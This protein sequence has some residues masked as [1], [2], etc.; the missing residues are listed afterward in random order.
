M[1][2][3]AL[4]RHAR[5]L[6]PLG[7]A[8]LIAIGLSAPAMAAFQLAPALP[9]MET[10]FSGD[11]KQTSDFEGWEDKARDLAIQPDGKTVAVGTVD[12]GSEGDPILDFGLARYNEDGS[13][14]ATFGGGGTQTTDVNGEHDQLSAVA[15]QADGKIVVTGVTDHKLALARY[16]S[17]GTLDA[18][19]ANGGIQI[20]DFGGPWSGGSGVALQTDGRIIVGGSVDDGSQV[21]Y[22]VARYNTD[23]S[24]DGS[25]GAG[26]SQLTFM[27]DGGATSLGLQADDKIVVAGTNGSE[28]GVVR[29]DSFG[30]LD[31][32]FS[33]DGIQTTAI[34][35][36]AYANDLGIQPDGRIVVAGAA[37][38]DGS[39]SGFA[40]VRYNSFGTL[41]NTFSGD[42]VQVTGRVGMDV[43]GTA[44]TI[45]PDSKIVAAGSSSM[46][47]GSGSDF[48]LARYDA[49]GTLDNT[50]SG[51]GFQTTDFGSHALANAAAA[52]PDG[53]ITVAGEAFGNS[54]MDF[55]VARYNH[56][57]SLDADAPNPPPASDPFPGP[58]SSP[59]TI[60]GS[61]RR[62]VLHGTAGHDVICARGG[63]DVVYGN[64]GNDLIYGNRGDDRLYGGPGRDRLFGGAGKDMLRGGHQRDRLNTRDHVRGNDFA[65]AGRGNDSCRTN[66]RDLRRSC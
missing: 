46:N 56:D 4:R 36:Y 52:R 20:T 54:S 27:N 43:W 65:Y 51:D 49:D 28:F 23:G 19:F 2:P 42:G 13:L 7:S 22:M 21:S 63:A 10:H 29:Y 3:H 44:L 5:T 48:A 11:G 30:N 64:G 18:S 61:P 15:L 39:T 9:V 41:D 38:T 60:I 26:G 58:S 8:L 12:V 62:D 50:F 6:V 14:D 59:C 16:T 53:K 25:F 66:R 31:N 34:G 35:T 55:A 24:P 17:S 45:Q 37:S 57:G 40:L 32:S 1:T 33:G 47:D